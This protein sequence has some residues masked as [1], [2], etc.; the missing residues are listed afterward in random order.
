MYVANIPKLLAQYIQNIPEEINVVADNI[1]RCY[2]QIV[3][4]DL[5][6]QPVNQY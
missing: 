4:L 3:T 2:N 1:I 5:S 6:L